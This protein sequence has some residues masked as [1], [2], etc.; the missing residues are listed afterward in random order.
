VLPVAAQ[1]ASFP[2]A[3]SIIKAQTEHLNAPGTAPTV[4]YFISSLDLAEASPQRFAQ[5]V[6]GHWNI[7]NGSH[8]QRDTL[9]RED[10]HTMRQHRGAHILSSLRQLALCLHSLQAAA[11]PNAK[12]RIKHRTQLTL[13]NLAASIRLLNSPPEE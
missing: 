12:L 10:H 9:W 2:F 5:L 7:E 1:T 4:R 3:R 6:R 11:Q 8:W 13:F